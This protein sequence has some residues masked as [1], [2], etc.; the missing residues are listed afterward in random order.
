MTIDRTQSTRR[1]FTLVEILVVMVILGVLAAIVVPQFVDASDDAKEASLVASIQTMRKQIDLY[2]LQHGGRGPHVN[3]SGQLDAA[4]GIARLLGRTDKYGALDSNGRYGPYL[5]SWPANPFC[6]DAVASL[7]ASGIN[8]KPP[9]NGVTGWY[10]HVE[11]CLISANSTTG[12]EA[13]DPD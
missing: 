4:N 13:L 3:E 8:P 12:G 1:G 2:K 7:I 10:Y 6:D 9:R 5:Q 11:T